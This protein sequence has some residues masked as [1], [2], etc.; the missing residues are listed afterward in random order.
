VRH[1]C[2]LAPA[3]LGCVCCVYWCCCI[4]HFV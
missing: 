1:P 4:C 2:G 3:R